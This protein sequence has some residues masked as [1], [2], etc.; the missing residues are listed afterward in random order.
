M[1]RHFILLPIVMVLA[2][3]LVARAAEKAGEKSPEAEI[4]QAIAALEEN[5]NRGDA[6]G[7]AACWTPD[8]EFIGPRGERIVGRQNIE[9]AFSEFLAA[10]KTS[11]LRLGIASWRLVADD[12]ALVD[13]LT[14]MTPVPEGVEAEPASTAVLVKRDGRWLIGSMHETLSREPSHY[15]R[16]KGLEW[17]VG[18]WA[19]EGTGESG[20]SVRSTCDWT[21]NESYLIRKFTVE[22]KK[23]VVRSGTEVIGWDPR[24]RRIRSWTFD[25]DG[26]FGESTWTHDGRRWTIAYTGTLANGGDVSS[27]HV[28]TPV[29]ADTADRPVEGPHDRRRKAARSAR[30][31]AQASPDHERSEIQ[32][33]RAEPQSAPAASCRP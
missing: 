29:D 21:A 15:L 10:H 12:V 32:A 1:P 6:K 11:K 22:R 4:R 20:I 8:G 19:A 5:F 3:V 16:L 23:G 31:Q 25:S 33:G 2:A 26:G 28:V 30:G 18:D 14:E 7:L 9:A 17:M 24:L 27:V 13:L